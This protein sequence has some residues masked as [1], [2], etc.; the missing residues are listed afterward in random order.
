MW[1]VVP[2]QLWRLLEWPE[3]DRYDLSS[4]QRVAGGGSVWPP[5]LLRALEKKLP[6]V[7]RTVGY[8]MTETTSCGTSLKSAATFD[9]PDSIGQAGPT[10]E[11][12]IRDPFDN[13][14]LVEG[15]S[16]KSVFARR[17][18][19]SDIGRILKPRG[20]RWSL[21]GGTTRAITASYGTDSC[22]WEDE[23]PT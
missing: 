8:G 23:G 2:T 9:H 21:T 7:Q 18:R 15:R 3:L 19:F 1:S 14:V 10:V 17:G 6:D 5:E 12:Q 20:R 4:L 11:I 13:Q 16:G 22:T